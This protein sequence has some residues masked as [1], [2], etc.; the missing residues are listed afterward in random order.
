LWK[1][2]HTAIRCPLASERVKRRGKKGGGIGHQS[3]IGGNLSLA[4]VSDGRI[5]VKTGSWGVWGCGNEVR[6][7]GAGGGGM[8]GGRGE[9][10]GGGGGGVWGGGLIKE[11][12]GW[13]R[14]Q[15]VC[16]WNLKS[17][18]FVGHRMR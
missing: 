12:G 17:A 13:A 11:G 1:F 5:P 9:V 6:G 2:I 18:G 10:V 3:N 8:V 15:V 16:E 14:G 4:S 7:G